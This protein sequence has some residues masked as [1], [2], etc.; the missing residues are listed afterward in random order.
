MEKEQ[1]V[2]NPVLDLIID[3]INKQKCLL[4][5][6]PNLLF[7][8]GKSINAHLNTKLAE[9]FP[10]D[11]TH[12]KGEEFLIFHKDDDRDLIKTQMQGPIKDFFEP[13]PPNKIYQEIAEIP[14][15]LVI[16]TSLDRTLNKAFDQKG[17]SYDYEFY[18]KNAVR[19]L[20]DDNVTL[21]Y[22][23]FGDYEDAESMILS[24]TD[25]FEYLEA[26][27][28]KGPRLKESLPEAPMI[29]FLGFS[30]EK[31][32]FQLLLWY[33]MKFRAVRKST[34]ITE[35]DIKLI[36]EKEFDIRF[37][38]DDANNLISQLYEAKRDGRIKEQKPIYKP[39]IFISYAWGGESGKIADKLE[40]FLPKAGLRTYRD[41]TTL[42]YKDDLIKFMNRIGEVD[43]GVVVISEKYLKSLNCMRELMNLYEKD[44][45]ID[46]IFPICLEDANFYNE[47]KLLEYGSYW[48][49][50]L[51]ERKKQKEEHGESANDLLEENDKLVEQIVENF[52]KVV[53]KL[54]DIN[55]SNA[56]VHMNSKFV[57][58]IAEI[59]KGFK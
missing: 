17:I 43:G 49:K 9:I 59:K 44:N 14:F 48:K 1:R 47:A 3:N 20:P 30:F 37:D 38:C 2:K 29:L 42:R 25:L 26:I 12:Y 21:I 27:F 56:Q 11:V 34:K 4:F 5:L 16:N 40:K 28:N 7:E 18:H 32:Y 31:W 15:K 46:I 33:V 36:C 35:N 51:E 39:E 19:K 24:H 45:F 23:I 54:I 50:V 58:L 10:Y 53:K 57:D 52:Y 55:L 6:G 8:D 41:E 13:L 22:N